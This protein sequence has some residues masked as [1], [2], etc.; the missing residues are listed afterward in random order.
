MVSF[1]GFYNITIARFYI[2]RNIFIY[3]LRMVKF[4]E[5]KT[6]LG[7]RCFKSYFKYL[8]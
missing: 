8:N 1:L 7:R 3:I 6:F 2:L 4:I 5:S